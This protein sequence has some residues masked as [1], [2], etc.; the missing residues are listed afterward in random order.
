MSLPAAKFQSQFFTEELFVLMKHLKRLLSLLLVCCLAA[1]VF[2]VSAGAAS[3]EGSCGENV[4]WVLDT[5]T[6]TLTISGTGP[7]KDWSYANSTPWADHRD[8]IKKVVVGSGV[9][10]IGKNAFSMYANATQLTSVSLPDTVTAIGDGA[11]A[12]CDALE[13]CPLSDKITSIGMNAFL[14]CAKLNMSRL[15]ASLTTLGESAFN[16]CESIGPVLDIPEGV[17][18]IP[19]DA[20]AG[21]S[22]V[23]SLTI[24][25][26]VTSIGSGAFC[27]TSIQK[28]VVPSTV[29]AIGSSAFS[30][31]KTLLHAD[32]Q[33]GTSLGYL[34]FSGCSALKKITFHKLV[35]L[36]TWMGMNFYGCD[37]LEYLYFP[38]TTTYISEINCK[39]LKTVCIVNPDCEI[40]ASGNLGTVGQTTIY[41]EAD[42]TAKAYA[43]DKG[44]SFKLLGTQPNEPADPVISQVTDPGTGTG[45]VN[46]S[47]PQFKDVSAGAYYSDAVAWAVENNVTSGTSNT[48]FS[49]DSVC[50]RAQAV[51]FLWRAAG[52][53]DVS[54]SN[55]F[56]D[57]SSSDYYYKAVLWAVQNGI[58]SGT[59]AK[60]FSPDLVCQRSQIV[61]FLY[62]YAG[63]PSVSGNNP[64]RDVSSSAYYYNAVQWAINHNVTS[65]T[66]AGQFSPESTCTRA[67]I[68][69]FLYRYIAQ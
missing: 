13:S 43:L 56:S 67:Q 49:P 40:Q 62:R 17:T 28:V 25:E 32:L 7:M 52:S 29:E 33:G 66:G 6:G 14:D 48:T 12:C 41:G 4:T 45:T 15:P 20:F 16:G 18:Q 30:D 69:T 37:A 23:K 1:A 19:R 8:A 24:P 34:A 9:T 65:G 11:F 35:T 55:P 27:E 39:N 42:S 44:Y 10:Y 5:D 31:I 54:G 50:T 3:Y 21:C 2:P 64:F 36:G 53:P 22:G 46:P 47:V 38:E 60:T 61:T 51:T 63:S 26:G 68:V 59:G 58:T 57:I